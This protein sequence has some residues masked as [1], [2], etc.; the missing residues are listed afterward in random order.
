MERINPGDPREIVRMEVVFDNETWTTSDPVPRYVA[1]EAMR[2]F[3]EQAT[4]VYGK[5]V[6]QALIVPVI[7]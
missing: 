6:I 2:L 4:P 1:Q 7:P 5:R 3:G